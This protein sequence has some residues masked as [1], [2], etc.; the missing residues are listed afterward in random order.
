MGQYPAKLIS[1]ASSSAMQLLSFTIDA[2][3]FYS[4]NEI[5]GLST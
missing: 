3:Y 4:N 1:I 2:P 5:P